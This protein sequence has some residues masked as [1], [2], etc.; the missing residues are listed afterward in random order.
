ME[1]ILL[2]SPQNMVAYNSLRPSWDSMAQGLARAFLVPL[3]TDIN[4]ARNMR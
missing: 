1:L 2:A 3:H 4:T